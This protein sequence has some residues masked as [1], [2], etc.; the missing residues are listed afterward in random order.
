MIHLPVLFYFGLGWGKC[1]V[2]WSPS[3]SLSYGD[4]ANVQVA[5]GV[6]NTVPQSEMRHKK[7]ELIL[8]FR[9]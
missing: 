2:S 1:L 3:V 4:E 5:S 8:P 6:V 7:A 9:H